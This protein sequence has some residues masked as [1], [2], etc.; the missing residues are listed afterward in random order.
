MVITN[1]LRAGDGNFRHIVVAAPNL[2][3][4]SL[5][6][7]TGRFFHSTTVKLTLLAKLIITAIQT[8]QSPR[9]DE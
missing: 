3:R 5:C 1:T 6:A 9:N 8:F 4:A 7:K 2:R